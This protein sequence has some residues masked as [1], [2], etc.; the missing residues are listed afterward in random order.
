MGAG[1][2]PNDQKKCILDLPVQPDNSS[3]SAKHLA[4]PAFAKDRRCAATADGRSGLPV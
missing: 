3:Q 2:R 4:L 1:A